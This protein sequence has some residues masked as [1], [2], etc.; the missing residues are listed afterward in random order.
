MLEYALGAITGIVIG[1]YFLA[2]THKD[3]IARLNRAYDE[4]DKWRAAYFDIANKDKD[5]KSC[6]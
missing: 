4:V 5:G 1:M 2:I 3:E 6:A